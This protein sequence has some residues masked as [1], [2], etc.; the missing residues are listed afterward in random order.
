MR[1][2]FL[3]HDRHLFDLG[4]AGDAFSSFVSA[5]SADDEGSAAGFSSGGAAVAA[6]A[7]ATGLQRDSDC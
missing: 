1:P 2:T 5:A 6:P 3:R 7:D 4:L